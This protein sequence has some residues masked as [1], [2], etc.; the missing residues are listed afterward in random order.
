MTGRYN[1]LSWNNLAALA[2]RLEDA[3]DAALLRVSELEAQAPS[4]REQLA[5]LAH[6][7]WSGWM[8]YMFSCAASSTPTTPRA[9]CCR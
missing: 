7:Q 3:R 8:R 5:A 4:L 9:S 1:P 6:E 2:E